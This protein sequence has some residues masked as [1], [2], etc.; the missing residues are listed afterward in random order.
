MLL[1]L[2]VSATAPSGILP[3]LAEN[4][5]F[6][7]NEGEIWRETDCLL[8]RAGFE[9]VVPDLSETFLYPSGAVNW[10]GSHS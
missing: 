5:G 8:E 9:L 6:S 2:R 3:A 1:D 4:P 10:P 7:G